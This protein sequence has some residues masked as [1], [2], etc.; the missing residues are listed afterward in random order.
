MFLPA[1]NRF[2]MRAWRKCHFGV[3]TKCNT[4]IDDAARRDKDD[5]MKVGMDTME[6]YAMA[7]YPD[8]QQ[9]VGFHPS[10]RSRP[11]V[12]VYSALHGVYS[13]VVIKIGAESHDIYRSYS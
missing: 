11:Q 10:M 1:R 8:R 9:S 6:E 4:S 3:R 13:F 2:R 5:P 7:T 12:N